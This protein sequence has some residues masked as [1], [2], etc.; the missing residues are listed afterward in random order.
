MRYSTIRYD[1]LGDLDRGDTQ[2]EQKLLAAWVWVWGRKGRERASKA[3][4]SDYTQ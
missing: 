2:T 4:W 3:T 1:T